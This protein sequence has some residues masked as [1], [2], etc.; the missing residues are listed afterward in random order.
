MHDGATATD[1]DDDDDDDDEKSIALHDLG[2]VRV[3]SL[4]IRSSNRL[5]AIQSEWVSESKSHKQ[6]FN[7]WWML[8]NFF[9]PYEESK[10]KN[11]IQLL[12]YS[13]DDFNVNVTKNTLQS[14]AH[15]PKSNKHRGLWWTHFVCVFY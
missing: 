10:T 4:S 13:I 1:V 12:Y 3:H 9:R 15:E 11:V 14:V 8:C 7:S 2:V 6:F 5:Q